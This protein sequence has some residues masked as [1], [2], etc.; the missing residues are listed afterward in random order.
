MAGNEW[1][2]PQQYM[3]AHCFCMI[4]VVVEYSLLLLFNV[5]IY[6]VLLRLLLLWLVLCSFFSCPPRFNYI[7]IIM[8][9]CHSKHPYITS[10]DFLSFMWGVVQSAILFDLKAFAT[11]KKTL[12]P[13]AWLRKLPD[14]QPDS[15]ATGP[16]AWPVIACLLSSLAESQMACPAK[17]WIIQLTHLGHAGLLAPDLFAG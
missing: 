15:I 2:D 12:S 14:V 6:Y 1:Y 17:P 3:G 7:R 4:L 8:Q 9:G 5:H 10:N 11:P 16:M 13:L